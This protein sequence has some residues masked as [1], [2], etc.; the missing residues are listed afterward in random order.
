MLRPC[1]PWKALVTKYWSERPEQPMSLTSTTC[2][3]SSSRLTRASFSRS[4][5][6][7]WPQ[8]GQNG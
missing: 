2:L 8:P 3:G 6:G 1:R 4:R 7:P 5:I